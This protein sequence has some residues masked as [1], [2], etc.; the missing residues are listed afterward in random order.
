MT[1]PWR[2]AARSVVEHGPFTAAEIDQPV[3]LVQH[4]SCAIPG[5]RE[6]VFTRCCGKEIRLERPMWPCEIPPS[7]GLSTGCRERPYALCGDG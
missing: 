3:H 1:D 7:T 2:A 6:V 5:K 4:P